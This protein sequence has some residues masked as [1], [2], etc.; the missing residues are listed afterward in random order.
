MKLDYQDIGAFI[1]HVR[2]EALDTGKSLTTIDEMLEFLD[3]NPDGYIRM[4]RRTGAYS[5]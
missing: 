4:I 5:D 1:E 3:K 2:E